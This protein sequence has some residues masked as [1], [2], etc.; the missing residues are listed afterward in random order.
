M[1]EEDAKFGD[2]YWV[3]KEAPESGASASPHVRWHVWP[4]AARTTWAECPGSPATKSLK[5]CPA[6]AMPEIHTTLE[7]RRVVDG[8]Y[9]HPVYKG[10]HGACRKDARSRHCPKMR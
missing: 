2:V 6:K 5:T 3:T 1:P 9:I 10:G 4:S 7:H 8:R